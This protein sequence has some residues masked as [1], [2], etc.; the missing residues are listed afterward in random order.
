[1]AVYASTVSVCVGWRLF[2]D[3]Q[4]SLLHFSSFFPR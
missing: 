2:G 1:M 3:A 4:C